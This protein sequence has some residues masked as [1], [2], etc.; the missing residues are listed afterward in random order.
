MY[1]C[2]N[3]AVFERLF[4]RLTYIICDGVLGFVRADLTQII[5]HT[6]WSQ[7]QYSTCP[8]IHQLG[9]GQH[10]RW[11][12]RQIEKRKQGSYSNNEIKFQYI[13]AYSRMDRTKFPGHFFPWKQ[14]SIMSKETLLHEWTHQVSGNILYIYKHH[15]SR[16]DMHTRLL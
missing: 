6:H 9:L 16:P 8:W 7:K 10:F 2:A 13:P 1:H 3:V 4:T 15:L 14:S 11:K 12:G 5:E